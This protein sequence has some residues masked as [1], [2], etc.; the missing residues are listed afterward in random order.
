[1]Y[2]NWIPQ[3]IQKRVFLFILQQ[4]LL[5]SGIELPNLEEVLYNNIHLRDVAIDPEKVTKIPGL[6]LRHGNLR[7]VLLRGSVKDGAR[8]EIDGVDLVLAPSI[9]NLRQDIE[10]AQAL[11][12]QS[13][14]DLTLTILLDSPELSGESG[15]FSADLSGSAA[16]PGADSDGSQSNPQT[17]LEQPQMAASPALDTKPPSSLG[18]VM[19]KAIDIA[20]LK[21]Q[22]RVTN[23][24]VKIIVEP[25]DLLFE[26]DEIIFLYK[27][28][29]KLLSVKGVKVS[30]GRPF[31]E[32]GIRGH[33]SS[34]RA[35]GKKTE[36]SN[37]G[38]SSNSS[39]SSSEEEFSDDNADDDSLNDSM[40]FTH[41]EASSIYMSAAT[42]FATEEKV[43]SGSMPQTEPPVMLL[44]IDCVDILF[45]NVSPLSSVRVDIHT[46]NVAAVPLLPSISL[47]LNSLLKL[48][49][50]STH[51]LRKKNSSKKQ[52]Q[53]TSA[54]TNQVPHMS[55]DKEDPGS[56][57]L[58]KFHIGKLEVSLTSALGTLG[59]FSSF[60]NDV[61]IVACN[62]TMRLKDE[63]L[64]YGGLES[65]EVLR[66]VDSNKS[67]VF[68][69][70][71]SSK[72]KSP[73]ANSQKADTALF[74]PP[75]VPRKADLRFEYST[76]RKQNETRASE[77]TLLVSRPGVLR[78]DPQTLRYLM[79][80]S[81]WI[82]AINDNLDNLIRS[83]QQFETVLVSL[84][85]V[86]SKRATS[87]QFSSQVIL[88]TSS[89]DLALQLSADTLLQALILPISYDKIQDHLNV[90]RITVGVKTNNTTNNLL[91]AS[92]IRFRITPLTIDSFHYSA[93]GAS[94]RKARMQSPQ[95]CVI[96]EIT[97]SVEISVVLS[98]IRDLKTFLSDFQAVDDVN[99]LDKAGLDQSGEPRHHLKVN[100]LMS[101]IHSSQKRFK[102]LNSA[103]IILG[104][105][106]SL[107]LSMRLL[108][109]RLKFSLREE[110][111]AFGS[112]E[113]TMEDIEVLR[114]NSGLRGH[115]MTV[116][117]KRR[118]VDEFLI[119]R[120][121]IESQKFPMIQFCKMASGKA[122]F[123]VVN[124]DFHVDFYANWLKLLSAAKEQSCISPTKEHVERIKGQEKDL[125]IRIVY[126]DIAVGIV[127]GRL[128]SKLCVA[129]ETGSLEVNLNT[130]Q[131]GIKSSFRNL[132]FL[133]IDEAKIIKAKN[134]SETSA[135]LCSRLLSAGYVEVGH[136][137][138]LHVGVTIAS[139]D[140][141][142]Q[143]KYLPFA[144]EVS[145]VETKINIDNMCFDLCADSAHTLLQTL[146]DMK[147]PVLFKDEEKFK[148]H[149]SKGFVFPPDVLCDS[150]DEDVVAEAEST[151][152]P[153]PETNGFC[154][155]DE[156]YSKRTPKDELSGRMST[157]DLNDSSLASKQGSSL[158]LVESHFIQKE[159]T[160]PRTILQFSLALNLK[161]VE[162]F[163]HDGYDW[164]LTRKSIK[165]AVKSLEEQSK[166]PKDSVKDDML[167]FAQQEAFRAD[168]FEKSDVEGLGSECEGHPSSDDPSDFKVSQ[169]LFQSIH[170][171]TAKNVD[172]S[173]LIE[174]INAQVRGNDAVKDAEAHTNVQVDKTF[175]DL[176]LKR[177]NDHKLS[178]ECKNLSVDVRSFPI[179]NESPRDL[180]SVSRPQLV[181]KV[182]VRLDTID[183]K[184]NVQSST[185]NRML[186]YMNALG[187]REI[188]TDMLSL[189]ITNVRPDSQMPFTEA[190][191]ALKILPLR[192]FVDQDT[193]GF[194]MRFF[195]FRDS[196][197]A[198]P[199]DELLYVQKLTIEPI[200]VKFD[201][202]PKSIDFAGI[203]SGNNAELA[204][205]FI[206]D[207][208]D[209]RLKKAVIYGA[210]GFP[211]VG[212][213][214]GQVYGPYIQKHQLSGLLAGLA[215]IKSIINVGNGVRD[216][217]TIPVKEYKRD[218]RLLHGLQKGS[219]SFA[220]V[221]TNE[222]LRLGVKLAS[223]AQVVLE[224]LEEY[225]GGEG[226]SARRPKKRSSVGKP[227]LPRRKISEKR[228]LLESSQILRSSVAVDT[229]RYL[230]PMLYIHS[231]IDEEE[232]DS[233][234]GH[235]QSSILVFNDA[236]DPDDNDDS[237]SED[238]EV[239][240]TSLY[241]NQPANPKEGLK[242]AF[243]SMGK[244][245]KESKHKIREL[246]RELKSAES[247]QD[248]LISVA[249]SSPVIVI[250]PLIGGTEAMMKTLMGLSNGIDSRSLQ[251]SH[252]KYRID[253]E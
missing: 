33:T 150:E 117:V 153:N 158:Q 232:L 179:E 224:N 14:A 195:G 90:P 144:K 2:S 234:L 244:N 125:M 69:F 91:T 71:S 36:S 43:K 50:L 101:S 17:P 89:F 100:H 207:G 64:T 184:D 242:S 131:F 134:I 199:V 218:G 93:A 197:F 11:L 34:N 210:H 156:Y 208:S 106:P 168:Q 29:I 123:E 229:D 175:K 238:T 212:R 54:G 209:L 223:G 6:R 44:Y 172:A 137:N 28:G 47:V 160:V 40:L 103:K 79:N 159:N 76:F 245:L 86:S 1:M 96:N 211:K 149:V 15:E 152:A 4:L 3:N 193:L 155:V 203:R 243:K 41:E 233:E 154:V 146:S 169:T 120:F 186:T 181:S 45:Q 214:L 221:T 187:E 145:M 10:N 92:D 58:E 116:A 225:F 67:Q 5:F 230:R 75:P 49:K 70:D 227:K 126:H 196:R 185:W 62:F 139:E 200:R 98:V 140:E 82:L 132:K 147:E 32:A 128:P 219:L 198:L 142:L 26:I 24:S 105:V 99:C 164:K 204:N 171:E 192:L 162:V 46:I 38:S 246:K 173:N 30:V 163:F 7:S 73:E 56:A 114:T 249:K 16:K 39:S 12:A 94:P 190:V 107:G 180:M 20:L 84:L 51:Q 109:P 65:L 135:T 167:H 102:R 27:S 206:L 77:L 213:A 23:I 253:K 188:G 220:K 112:L 247:V 13:S 83:M 226:A 151:N 189:S 215:P 66:Y 201:Y 178:A 63:S 87:S 22:V 174:I 231:A 111:G 143:S 251:E 52:G 237:L 21:L 104:D 248:Q 68:Y 191:I 48:F 202:K 129:L 35:S 9:D 61:S 165:R 205:F 53:R 183:V 25:A 177:S 31:L 241:S 166:R 127:P 115:V 72:S 157:V 97:G 228:N 55:S 74:T 170:I 240:V 121:S 239:K 8:L 124:R 42:G 141:F 222:L 118:I 216:L 57:V 136:L 130:D 148:T 252:D 110:S 113:L 235:L 60:Q 19:S 88:Q 176:K 119:S 182:D 95:S 138:L 194:V 161:L 133:L 81:L 78:L 122:L 18:G 108:V 250:R 59:Q 80:A 236:S 85:G 217:V 37:G